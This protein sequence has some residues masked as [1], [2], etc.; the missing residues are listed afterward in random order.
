M[1]SSAV[2]PDRWPRR[3]MKSGDGNCLAKEHCTA[4]AV[5]LLLVTFAVSEVVN[6]GN[7]A[8]RL[9]VGQKRKR[10]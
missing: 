5:R 9:P 3:S 10:R 7:F 2:N 4:I 6:L 1:K 8:D